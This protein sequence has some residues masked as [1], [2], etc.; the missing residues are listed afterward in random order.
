MTHLFS[1]SGYGFMYRGQRAIYLALTNFVRRF[2][3][4]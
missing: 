2:V 3:I 1:V 4:R